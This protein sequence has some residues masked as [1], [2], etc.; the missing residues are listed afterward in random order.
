[1]DAELRGQAN[2]SRGDSHDARMQHPKATL[3]SGAKPMQHSQN[4]TE[5]RAK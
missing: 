1:M 5:M 3:E 4:Q 2:F